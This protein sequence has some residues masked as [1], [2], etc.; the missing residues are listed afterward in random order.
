M[1]L[2]HRRGWRGGARWVAALLASVA[3]AAAGPGRAASPPPVAGGSAERLTV[4]GSQL[5]TPDGKPI[6]LRGFNWGRWGTALPEDG[7]ENAARGATVVRIPFR[8]YFNGPKA[9]IRDS[10]SP[11]HFDPAGL[12]Q[13]DEQIKWATDAGLWVVLFAGSDKGAGDSSEANY[14]NNPALRREFMEAWA[15]IV[16]RY[17]DTPRIAAYE[18]LSEPHPKKPVTAADLR[19]FYEEVIGTVRRYDTRTPVAI[20][21]PDHYSIEQLQGVYTRVDD[22]IIYTANFYLPKE[23]C[24]PWRRK[25]ALGPPTAYPGP[26]VDRNGVSRRVDPQGLADLLKPALEFRE[27]NRVPVFIDQ[28]GCVS[29]APGVLDY[30]RDVLA[31]FKQQ[32]VHWAFWTYRVYH[33]GANEHGL[34]YNPGDGWKIKPELDAV[35]RKGMAP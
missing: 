18:L 21:G 15:F 9:D 22:K 7:R 19:S 5:L 28:V 10:G 17:K 3:G 25:D 16:Q 32:Q 24:K 4:S 35:L 6:W 20:G 2:G 26:Y 27:R 33:A 14:W 29:S 23:Y 11:G 34:W 1:G 30:T 12:K 31:L 13:L 8:W